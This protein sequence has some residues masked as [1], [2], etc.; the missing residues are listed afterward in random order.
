MRK[1]LLSLDN[2]GTY[3]KAALLDTAGYQIGI[4]KRHNGIINLGNGM[5]EFDQEQLWETNCRCIRDV[6]QQ[7]GISPT[8][9]AC[10]GFAGQ[11]K[12]L[13]MIDRNGQ[14]FRNAIASSDSRAES[15]CHM[16]RMDGTAE[17]MFPKLFQYPVP[18]QTVPILR[19]LKQNEP[20]NYARIGYVF[21][22][23]DF[24]LYCLTGKIFAGKG[25][26]SGTLLV[27]LL[28]QDYDYELLEN[29]GIPEMQNCLPELKWDTELCGTVSV[30]AAA[31]CGL[32]A[33]T[34]VSAGMF[35]VD[36][37]ALAMGV[38]NPNDVFTIFGTCGI[39]GYISNKP[40]TNRTISFNSLYSLKNT[41]LI[42]EGSNASS[43]VLEWV[44]KV[45]L[46][47]SGD[48]EMYYSVNAMVDVDP[49]EDD[50]LV[51]FPSLTGFLHGGGKGSVY[52][53][54]A[55]V[56]VSPE[57]GRNQMLRAV[58]EGVVFTHMV[59]LE[60]L[61]QNCDRPKKIRVAG[62]ATN[63]SVWMQMYADALQIPVEIEENCEMGTKGVA[64]ASAVAVGIY[65]DIQEAVATMSRPGTLIQ[66]RAEYAHIYKKKFERF[67]KV[68]NA[69]DE[70]W[71][72]LRDK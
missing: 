41:Y 64:I 37:S 24:L 32:C 9:I 1:Y 6:L 48:S 33:G 67:K 27:N 35:D 3:I 66:P 65:H 42:E 29:F 22:M 46:N 52:S 59:Q 50:H 55:W 45:L 56:G 21:S 12:G 40:V 20:E 63:S 18:G 17:R 5:I 8:E 10:V 39:N 19:W 30:E 23:K 26:Q 53:R 62:G 49:N 51:F 31:F 43:G 28:T 71:P 14:S 7:T 47:D 13:Y 15:Y 11:G 69:M 58:Y 68:M 2:G 34:P 72:A 4:A 70:V 16:W 60:H 57:H 44:L 38:A 54:G 36:A 61:L 25:S